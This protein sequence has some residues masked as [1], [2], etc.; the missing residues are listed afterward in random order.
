M[1][2]F[3]I[4]LVLSALL[5]SLVTGFLFAYAAVIMPVSMVTRN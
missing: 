3:E 5:C 4:A 2:V 1:S